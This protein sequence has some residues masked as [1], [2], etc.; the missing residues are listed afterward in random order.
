MNFFALMKKKM[1]AFVS[2][3]KSLTINV[4]QRVYADDDLPISPYQHARK[5]T[6]EWGVTN[7]RTQ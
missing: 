6:F 1:S 3:S 5:L 7:G 2:N 4:V